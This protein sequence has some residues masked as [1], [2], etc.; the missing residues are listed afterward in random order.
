[1]NQNTCTRKNRNPWSH[2]FL[3]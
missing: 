1:M 3:L 2:A